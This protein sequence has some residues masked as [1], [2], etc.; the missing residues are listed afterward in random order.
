MIQDSPWPSA[1]LANTEVSN[2]QWYKIQGPPLWSSGLVVSVP[3]YRS[4]GPGSILS[5]TR[6]SEEY[7]V[8][9]GVHS[10][11][12]VQYRG[13]GVELS[14]LQAIVLALVNDGW[15][16]VWSSRWSDWQGKPKYS[17]KTC[18]VP[19]CPPQIPHDL[20]LAWSHTAAVGNRRLTAWATTV[21]AFGLLCIVN[22]IAGSVNSLG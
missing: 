22:L 5:A 9:N 1:S 16:W 11:S 2:E 6:F 8:R 18:S 4:R 20:T 12:R 3:G 7:W 10:T 21:L 15:W 19:L 13:G 14:P 17:E